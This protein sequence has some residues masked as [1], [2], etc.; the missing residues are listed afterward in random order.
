MTPRNL[1][2]SLLGLGLTLLS[3]AS[4]PF[5]FAQDATSEATQAAEPVSTEA[6]EAATEATAS[7]FNISQV[8]DL[9]QPA[10]EPTGD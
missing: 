3:M 4:V 2:I 1:S 6:S 5:V 9:S 10:V 7:A 8:Y